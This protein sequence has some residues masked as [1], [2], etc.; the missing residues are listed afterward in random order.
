MSILFF[1]N[2]IE[3]QLRRH[4]F[5][6]PPDEKTIREPY[7]SVSTVPIVYAATILTMRGMGVVIAGNL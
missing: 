5:D 4:Y 6:T 3:L 1:F 2:N 7:Y